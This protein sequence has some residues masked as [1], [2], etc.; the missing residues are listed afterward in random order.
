M[1]T[2]VKQP[3]STYFLHTQY[4]GTV[5]D[6]T[7]DWHTPEP[8]HRRGTVVRLTSKVNQILLPDL[9]TKR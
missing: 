8:S 3:T 5:T 2:K 9:K 1:Y 4:H 6:S 7:S